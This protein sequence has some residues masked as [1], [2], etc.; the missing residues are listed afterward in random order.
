MSL[1]YLI[2]SL[3]RAA[4]HK[5]LTNPISPTVRRQS[6]HPVVTKPAAKAPATRPA[7]GC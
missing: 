4:N 1:D 6:P 7:R 5:T 2:A 3:Q